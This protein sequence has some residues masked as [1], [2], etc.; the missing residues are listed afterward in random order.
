MFN[1]ILSGGSRAAATSKM[2]RFV[3]VVNGFQPL[4]IM[5]KRSILDV[6]A[7]LDLP[8]ILNAALINFNF[9]LYVQTVSNRILLLQLVFRWPIILEK[10]YCKFY[11][12]MQLDTRFY[13]FL[14]LMN[15][16][17]LQCVNLFIA[18]IILDSLHEA[19]TEHDGQRY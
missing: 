18:I 19:R 2:E 17:N 9:K 5:T 8:L 10:S 3:T 14:H 15:Y 1:R 11:E 7:A 13:I 4:T 16:L 6:A 12:F